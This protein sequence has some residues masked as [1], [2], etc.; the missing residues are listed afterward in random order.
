MSAP[1]GLTKRTL[2]LYIVV[3]NGARTGD[4]K[5]IENVRSFW[6]LNAQA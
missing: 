2:I 6:T 3:V 5:E 1:F 4:Q